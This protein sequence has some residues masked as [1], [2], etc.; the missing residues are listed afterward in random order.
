MY[1]SSTFSSTSSI[2]SGCLR[3]LQIS[4]FY[5]GRVLY[6]PPIS[7]RHY[8]FYYPLSSPLLISLPLPP[9]PLSLLSVTHVIPRHCR[10]P[11]HHCHP[12]RLR[13]PIHPPHPQ[14]SSLK[15][16]EQICTVYSCSVTFFSLYY[17]FKHTCLRSLFSR[18]LLTANKLMPSTDTARSHFIQGALR[19]IKGVP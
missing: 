19:D 16:K 14:H 11:R 1:A 3:V 4:S 12:C 13:H 9:I 15:G 10:Q 18:W 8:S 2:I 7:H 17:S 5:K 6:I